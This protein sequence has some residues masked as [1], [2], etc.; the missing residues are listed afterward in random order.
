VFL[1]GLWLKAVEPPLNYPLMYAFGF[2]TSMLSTYFLVKVQ[3]PSAKPAPKSGSS[4]NLK[5]FLR[6][7]QAYPAFQRITLNTLIHG[8][9]VWLAA[10]LYMLLYVRDLHADEAWIGLQATIGSLATIFGFGFWRWL[11]ARWGE[12]RTLKVTI[13]LAGFTPF[14]VGI[15]QNLALILLVVAFNG[16]LAGGVAL[17]HF[18]TLLKSMPVDARPEYT[19]LYTTIMNIGAFL[20]P[21]AGVALAGVFGNANM[22]IVCGI[23]IFLGSSS[24][25]WRP[26]ILPE[27]KHDP[28][29][30]E[31]A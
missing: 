14:L 15:S 24:F 18:N 9:G 22:L 16:W 31:S 4:V 10:P 23:L 3:I 1:F 2:L 21:F 6:A 7:L 12:P 26:V 20:C 13:M 11:I 29:P 17:S 27:V 30:P 8:V 25:L 28:Q 19:A 5:A